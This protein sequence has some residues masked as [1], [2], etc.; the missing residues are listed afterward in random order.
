[1]E[2]IF[3]FGV[4]LGGLF[5]F[6]INLSFLFS[7]DDATKSAICIGDIV[8][9]MNHLVS[10]EIA[11]HTVT[12]CVSLINGD[13]SLFLF[14]VPILCMHVWTLAT[15][16]HAFDQDKLL[17]P[18]ILS[19][20]YSLVLWKTM[21]YATLMVWLFYKFSMEFSSAMVSRLFS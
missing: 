14:N 19:S 9:S 13:Y 7:L 1:M 4:F 16:S 6:I 21:Y 5:C 10:L 2:T 11:I 8:K 12:T 17:D 3:A 20:D 18:N 15:K